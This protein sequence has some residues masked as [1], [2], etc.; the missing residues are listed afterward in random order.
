MMAWTGGEEDLDDDLLVSASIARAT[1]E[2]PA[3]NLRPVL[4]VLCQTSQLSLL[5]RRNGVRRARGLLVVG[6]VPL[7]CRGGS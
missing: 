3:V 6:K 1:E 7:D 4:E 2:I 5:G